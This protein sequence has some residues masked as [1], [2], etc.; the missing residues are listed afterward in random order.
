MSKR[1]MLPIEIDEQK[2]D[3]ILKNINLTDT[4]FSESLG[5]EKSFLKHIRERQA[6][7]KPAWLLIKTMYGVD[8]QKIKEEPAPIEYTDSSKYTEITNDMVAQLIENKK[9]VV[10]MVDS[11]DRNVEDIKALLNTIIEKLS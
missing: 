1:N 9:I 6:I 11:L 8:I 10:N 2:L 7:S 3:M 4:K 5:Y